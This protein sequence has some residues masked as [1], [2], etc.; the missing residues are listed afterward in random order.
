MS[1]SAVTAESEFATYPGAKAPARRRFVASGGLRIAVHEWGDEKAPPLL[2]AHGGFDFSR[3]YDV[4]A[5]LLAAGG[6]RVVSW[7]QRGHGDSEHAALYTWDAD[8]RDALTVLDTVTCEPIPVIGHSKGGSLLT[9]LADA[10]PHRVS[11][12]VNIDGL[13]SRARHPDVAEH[14]RSRLLAKEL[15]GWLDHRRGVANAERKPGTMD[16]LAR[17]RGRMNPRLSHEWLLYLVAAGAQHDADGWRWKLDPSMRFGGFGPWRPEWTL[18]RLPG[19][20]VPML[21]FLA[22]ASEP[23]GWDTTEEILRPYLPPDA[24]IHTLPDTGHFIHI[25]RPREVVERVLR[26]LA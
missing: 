4:F 11:K 15:A 10:C 2:L 24:E 6:F 13:P 12:L 9:H 19:L 7:D 17:R 14:E 18:L 21:G 26:F 25:E 23:M 5:P 20:P 1:E 16:E 3:T 8:V 22:S